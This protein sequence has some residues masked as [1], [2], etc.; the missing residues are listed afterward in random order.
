MFYIWHRL[1][2]MLKWKRKAHLTFELDQEADL[3][4]Q[5]LAEEE[6]RPRAEI[7]AEILA[8]SLARLQDNNRYWELWQSL[9]PRQKEIAALICLGYTNRQIAARLTI[10]PE[11]VKTHV[12]NVLYKFNLHRKTDL[13]R[14][15]A[16]WDFSAWQG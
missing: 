5:R 2:K 15:L 13:Q 9:T 7:A 14:A 8:A 4:L 16:E 6:T 10:S 1:Q 3:T 11:T 12:R